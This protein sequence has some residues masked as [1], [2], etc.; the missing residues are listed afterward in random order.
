MRICA[1]TL[2]R[3]NEPVIS[4]GFDGRT[5]ACLPVKAQQHKKH[6]HKKKR[7]LKRKK[8][9]HYMNSCRQTRTMERKSQ[10]KTIKVCLFSVSLISFSCSCF[11]HWWWFLWI[12]QPLNHIRKWQGVPGVKGGIGDSP[13][14]V[15]PFGGWSVAPCHLNTR[16][17]GWSHTARGRRLNLERTILACWQ[18]WWNDFCHDG[19][20]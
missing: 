13:A 3:Q 6:T 9:N 2:E 11:S 19:G 8:K 14:P 18:I 15:R 20:Q 5:D 1:E 7:L 17:D 12:K 4:L 10:L 16:P